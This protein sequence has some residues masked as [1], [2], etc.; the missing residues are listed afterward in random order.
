MSVQLLL[1]NVDGAAV[2]EQSSAPHRL[3]QAAEHEEEEAGGG[4][5]LHR[6][7][8]LGKGGLIYVPVRND[9]VRNTVNITFIMKKELCDKPLKATGSIQKT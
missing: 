5:G 6:W 7:A 1:V 8:W 3:A 9:Q 2:Q 4:Q